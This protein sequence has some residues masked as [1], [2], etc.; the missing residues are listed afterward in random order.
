MQSKANRMMIPINM[1]RVN[2]WGVLGIHVLPG[3]F[4]VIQAM[5]RQLFNFIRWRL[6]F[7]SVNIALKILSCLIIQTAPVVQSRAAPPLETVTIDMNDAGLRSSAGYRA[8]GLCPGTQ[9]CQAFPLSIWCQLH[10][11]RRQWQKRLTTSRTSFFW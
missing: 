2:C 5:L 1:M 6:G 8:D 4:G 7:L 9:S 11:Q 3:R 10:Q